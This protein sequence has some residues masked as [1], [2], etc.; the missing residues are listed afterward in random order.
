M[1]IHASPTC[2]ISME[3]A[4]GYLI[5]EPHKGMRSM[6]F[7]MNEACLSVGLEGL[8]LSEAAYQ[9]A[10]DFSK[11]RRQGRSLNRERNDP[12]AEADC[13]L[14]HP[15]VRRMLLK[16]RSTN[17][18]MRGLTFYVANNIDISHNHPDEAK[19]QQAED[20]VSLLTPVVKSFFTDI[21]FLNTS[22]AMQVCGGIGYTTEWPIEQYMR[23]VRIAMIY[24][25]T[26]HIQALD[27]VG[28]KLLID[29]GRLIRTFGAE[30]GA[31]LASVKGDERL[32][33]FAKPTQD[34]FNTL[35]QLTMFLASNAPK[36]PELAAA[37]ASAYLNVFGS[38][39]FA[40]SWL[41]QCKYAVEQEDDF[42]K[43]KIKMARFY[44]RHVHP[45]IE[46]RKQIVLNG[47][48]AMMDFDESEF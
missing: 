6:F 11:D 44:F 36:D 20:I 3:N 41:H 8:A 14:V 46:A 29:G 4:E 12:N 26:N 18:A 5:G 42:A 2:V 28:R 22:E 34:A 15:D 16:V 38:A 1:G 19:R 33:E 27:L 35:T 47:K 13:I 30:F 31:L 45:E 48:D 37:V 24:E 32:T 43:T 39:A 10:L 17:E 9:A 23:D 25:G 40:F 7:M 21:G